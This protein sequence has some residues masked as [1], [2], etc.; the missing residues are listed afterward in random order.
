MKALI[1]GFGSI[2]KRHYD[3]LCG[4]IGSGNVGV[5][6]RRETGLDKSYGSL[7]E[8][9]DINEY[10][11]FVIA[12]KTCE[13]FEDLCHINN[14]VEDKIILCE[15]PLFERS[16]SMV[17]LKNHVYVGYNLRFHP[18]VMKCRELLGIYGKVLFVRSY[19]GQ[20]LPSWRPG[21]DYRD[22]YSAKKE[23]GGGIMMDCS[24]D[25]DIIRFLFGRIVSFNAYNDKISDLEITSD[26][27]FSMIGRTE[28]GV[29]FSLNMDYISKKAARVIEINTEEA[30]IVA[31]II[32]KTITLT[33]RSGETEI[34]HFPEIDRNTTYTAMHESIIEKKDNHCADYAD[35]LDIASIFDNVR[36]NNL[37]QV[38]Q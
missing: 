29:L 35:G 4:L 15:K 3:I 20:Y 19:V 28:G 22:S 25:I 36:K 14:S 11:Y 17:S 9:T 2:G 6:S 24:H 34:M 26:D 18:V 21:T 1:I 30:T 37:K 13:H 12:S 5:V 32:G 38:W 16:R 23:E 8:V 7:A 31:D 33:T 10:G 27:Y